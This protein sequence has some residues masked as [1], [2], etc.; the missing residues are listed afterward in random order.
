MNTN[1]D[2]DLEISR[3][4][5][6]A[7][8][9]ENRLQYLG[10]NEVLPLTVADMDFAAPPLV[11][12]AL[13]ERAAHPVYGYS[14]YPESLYES[15]LEWLQKRH[16][17]EVQREWILLTPGVVPALFAAVAAYTNADDGVIIQPPVYQPFFH[18]AETHQ[19]KLLENPLQLFN[20]RYSIDFE[21]LEQCAS[22]ARLLF[23]CSPHNPVGRVFSPQELNKV[24]E[25][26]ERHDLIVFSDEIHSDLL[27]PGFVHTPLGALNTGRVIT[28]VA[29]SKTFNIPGLNLAALVIPNQTHRE[30]IKAVFDSLHIGSANPFSVAAFEAAYRHGEDWL[31]QLL[32]YIKD[33]KNLVASFLQQQ[34]PLIKL[35]EPEATFLLWLDCRDLRL[36]D[37]RLKH[38][39]VEQAKCGI[40]PGTV[41]GVVGSGFVRMNIAVPRH[42]LAM[43]LERIKVAVLN[44]KK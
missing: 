9:Y 3:I 1:I 4:D 36:N 19:R 38:F 10:N 13:M 25:I 42:I 24:L 14:V 23:L 11:V 15:L 35:I 40:I 7:S 34:I 17:W 2:F 37:T 8:K 5:T 44:L 27:F 16:K 21:H 22:Q 33:S 29:P 39:F 43:A 6:H 26:A 32:V 28:A 12:A 20:A 30:A 18:A 31:N 41:F